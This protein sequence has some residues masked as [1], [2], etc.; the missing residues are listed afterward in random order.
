[1]VSSLLL[2]NLEL[3]P[4]LQTYCSNVEIST[5]FTSET[6]KTHAVSDTM[7]PEKSGIELITSETAW[8]FYRSGDR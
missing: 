6:G 8:L 1:M 2:I 3:F 7:L 5:P 4:S